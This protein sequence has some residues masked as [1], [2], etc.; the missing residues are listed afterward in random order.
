MWGIIRF[1]SSRNFVISGTALEHVLQ[2]QTFGQMSGESLHRTGERK[3]AVYSCGAAANLTMPVSVAKTRHI[4]RAVFPLSFCAVGKRLGGLR[5]CIKEPRRAEC[6]LWNMEFQQWHKDLS[7][8]V[9][10]YAL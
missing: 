6:A 4:G 7:I 10:G 5:N 8:W 3:L 1:R 9:Y 2:A